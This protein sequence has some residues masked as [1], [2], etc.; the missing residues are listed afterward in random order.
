M[1]RCWQH[2]RGVPVP[3]VTAAQMREVDRI[4]TEELKVGLLQMMELA[5]R[6]L[7]SLART[8]FLHERGP[9]PRVMVLA[10]TGGNGGGA[11]V[12]ARRLHAAGARVRVVTSVAPAAYVG[13]PQRQL[14]TL[15]RLEV[16]ISNWDEALSLRT[17]DLI[18]DGVI[19]YGLQ[20]PPRD[21]AGAMIGWVN[22]V[23]A[24]VLSLDVPSGLD[25][26]TG[27][28]STPTVLAAA[29][30]TLGLP[31]T[32]LCSPEGA[33][34]VGQL[35]L[36]DIGIPRQAYASLALA[37]GDLFQDSDLV[38]LT[39]TATPGKRND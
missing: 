29:T 38:H 18:I 22:G 33:P 4:M 17:P 6:H 2:P 30:L 9:G 14:E 24:P 15:R 8:L 37:V 5:G 11:M 1:T 13:T 12:A 28:P 23:A 10:G 16:P 39:R 26:T 21:G 32:G 20:G 35:Y 7:A 27:V 36:A 31:K 34:H 19:G 25:A 3:G